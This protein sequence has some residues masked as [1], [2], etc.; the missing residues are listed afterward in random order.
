MKNSQILNREGIILR[1]KDNLHI[2]KIT[3]IAIA[4]SAARELEEFFKMVLEEAIS[5]TNADAGSLYMVSEDSQYLDFKFVCTVSKGL[6]LGIAD[7][8]QWPSVPLYKELGEKNLNNF[9]AYVYHNRD[10]LALEDV[11]DQ[12]LFDNSGTKKYDGAN[13]YR[14]K[15]MLAVPLMNHEDDI[16][17][18]IQLINAQ[19]D[20]GKL[21]AFESAE[22][23]MVQAL[24]SLAAIAYTNNRLIFDLENLLSQF[25]KSI[26]SAIDH[27]SKYTGGHI[28]R[29]ARL[30]E[31]I[32]LLVKEDEVYFAE[33]SFSEDELKEISI[34]GWMHDIGKITTPVYIMDKSHK[35]ETIF[36]RVDLIEERINCVKNLAESYKLQNISATK[37]ELKKLNDKL[38]ETSDFIKNLNGGGEFLSTE[39]EEKLLEIF[40]NPIQFMGKEFS[41]ITE[42]EKKNL[43]IKKGTLL[44]E[45]ID[46][47][48]DHVSVTHEMLSGLTFPKKYK[49]VPLYAATHHE[50]L[51]GK[52]YPFGMDK[53]TLPLQSRILAV[54]DL[55]ESLTASDRPYKKGMPLS[56]A[57][58]I[59]C[60][61]VKDGEIDAKLVALLL[62]SKLIQTYA[63]EH[64]HD[65]QNDYYN[66]S[67]LK[68]I[69]EK[70]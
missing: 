55:F 54:A 51:N 31:D 56:Q 21:I 58:R 34:A 66:I 19:D 11:Y 29:V 18:V 53:D 9:V 33:V 64:L 24:S 48:R 6:T 35:L 44:P 59:M 36:D 47:M 3:E 5:Y 42:D 20:E 37:D 46:I 23:N 2:K 43:A 65:Y 60:Y 39:K 27:K 50:K 7:T 8:M 14:S 13:E 17:G 28:Q 4:L 57:L 49:N 41:L 32:A 30:C 61:M 26:A 45:E 63:N 70:N 10:T 38:D 15:S 52:G 69:Y 62:D 1:I 16:V 25:I 68:E 67:S 22:I 12:Q 40:E